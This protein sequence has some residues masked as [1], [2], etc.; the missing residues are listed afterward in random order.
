[1][2]SSA[3]PPSVAAGVDSGRAAWALTVNYGLA[4]PTGW[5]QVRENAIA[6]TRLSFGPDLGVRVASTVGATLRVPIGAGALSVA[7][8][9]TSLRGSVVLPDS[10]HF[11][12][13]TLAA[14]TVL[15]TRTELGDF[16]RV[17]IS[18]DRRLARVGR[19]G[20][21]DASAGLDATLLNFRLQGTLTPTSAGHETKEDFVTQELPAPFL[22]A[23]L[24]LPLGRRLVL[25]AAADGSGLP[26]VSSLRYE[27]GLVSITQRRLD[28]QAGVDVALAPRLSAGLGVQYTDFLQNE[29]SHEDG[30]QFELSSL[31]GILRLRWAF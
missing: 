5:V 8:A 2:G 29:Q 27:G 9:G 16:L 4:R 19:D 26:R 20:E 24:K 30:N 31:G 7:V 6:G 14:G 1:V 15:K 10:I 25:D 11:N 12:G 28:G 18:Y 23:E 13:S 17:V 21:L 3:A 22:G